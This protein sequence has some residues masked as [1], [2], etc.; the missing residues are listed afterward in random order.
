MKRI[1]L[2]IIFYFFLS[3][4]LSG[5]RKG[6]LSG[7]FE[8]AGKYDSLKIVLVPPSG[9]N[10]ETVAK[11]NRFEIKIPDGNLWVTYIL[12]AGTGKS[13]NSTDFTF[14]ILLNGN[15]QTNIKIN[16]Q[17]NKCTITGDK[18]SQEQNQYFQEL[19]QID[20]LR[21]AI[22]LSIE[23]ASDTE[24]KSNLQKKLNR[25][26][27]SE[28]SLNRAWVINHPESPFSITLIRLFIL[29]GWIEE[30][31]KEAYQ[32]LAPIPEDIKK[33]SSDYKIIMTSLYSGS[34]QE[35]YL[36]VAENTIAPDFAVMDTS[37][38]LIKL[39]DFSGS[40]VLI[41]FW[42]SW[43]APCKRS[44]PM[45]RSII[46]SYTPK[47]LKVLSI[48]MD[49]DSTL[50]KSSIRSDKMN[51]LQ[52]SDLKGQ[53]YTDINNMDYK[54]EISGVPQF[55]LISPKGIIISRI[56]GYGDNITEAEIRNKLDKIYSVTR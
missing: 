55:F 24:K 42:S 39:K 25:I 11:S 38:N 3:N 45:L 56:L 20:S 29:K 40:Y 30:S 46:K 10:T 50:W 15:S 19:F 13:G 37:G 4:A 31:K 8:N 36:N 17:S 26:N 14:P 23:N 5:Q 9:R 28:D 48:S 16:K 21:K 52:G 54:Y 6:Y 49:T 27:K 2:L 22:A 47:G 53:T 43:C 44:L 18:L 51:W 7:T 1:E 35:K 41:D 34:G 32:L 12:M 33:Q